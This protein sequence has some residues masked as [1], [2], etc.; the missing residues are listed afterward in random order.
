M[1]K[2]GI[3]EVVLVAVVLL[4][5]TSIA[6]LLLSPEEAGLSCPDT[7]LCGKVPLGG[8]VEVEEA[9]G[10]AV[11]DGANM[12][13]RFFFA[14]SLALNGMTIP[15][16]P[17]PN[18]P[19]PPPLLPKAIFRLNRGAVALGGGGALSQFWFGSRDVLGAFGFDLIVGLEFVVVVGVGE[20]GVD[21]ESFL[22]RGEENVGL[23]EDA[24]DVDGGG[25][26][27]RTPKFSQSFNCKVRNKVDAPCL[28][29]VQRRRL[30]VPNTIT[31]IFILI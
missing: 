1:F 15:P 5:F 7:L 9:F 16:P 10:N 20:G 22:L 24:E 14:Y 2:E 23:C 13:S 12:L 6:F 11:P 29:R 17:P 4:R 8:E 21:A 30:G 31:T 18:I 28:I 27:F 19:P 3:L 26:Q 25:L